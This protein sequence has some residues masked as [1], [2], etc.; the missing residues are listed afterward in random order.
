MSFKIKISEDNEPIAKA[1]GETIDELEN[2]FKN[3]K[4][5]YNGRGKR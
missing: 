5:K 3:L 2:I 4:I 1:K